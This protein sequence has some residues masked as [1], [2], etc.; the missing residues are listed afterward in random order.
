MK[1]MYTAAASTAQFSDIRTVFETPHVLI[2]LHGI[3]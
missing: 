3:M 2:F 1:Q